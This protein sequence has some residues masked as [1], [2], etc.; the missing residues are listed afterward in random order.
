VFEEVLEGEARVEEYLDNLTNVVL[1]LHVGGVLAHRVGVG[2]VPRIGGDET[3]GTLEV[4]GR[5]VEFGV[6]V[7]TGRLVPPPTVDL[8]ETRAG[9]V[10]YR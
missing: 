7:E 8:E 3:L 6:D 10:H 4:V 1:A 5:G 9:F 2:V